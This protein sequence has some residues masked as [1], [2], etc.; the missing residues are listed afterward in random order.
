MDRIINIGQRDF[1]QFITENHFY[2]DKTKFIKEWWEQRDVVTLIIRPEKFGK[3]LNISMLETFF[4]IEYADRGELFEGLSIWKEEKYR[5]LQGTYPVIS[6]SFADVKGAD[7][8]ETKKSLNQVLENLYN[9]NRFLLD[10]KLLDKNEKIYFQ[11]VTSDM[12]GL[13]A[14]WAIYKMSDFLF[15]YYGKHVIVLV[16]E[17]DAPMREAYVNGYWKEMAGLIRSMFNTSFK[18]NP[19]LEQAVMT[20]MTTSSEELI[21][22]DL[23]MEIIT[24]TSKKYTDSFGF[25]EEEVFDA[26]NEFGMSDRQADVKRWY[27]GFVFGN[28]D[29]LYNPWSVMNYLDKKELCIYWTDTHSYSLTGNVTQR[30]SRNVKASFE[31]L[32]SGEHLTVSIDETIAYDRL[33]VDENAIWSFLLASGYVK[34][35]RYEAITDAY[36]GWKKEY[37]LELTNFEVKALFREMIQQWFYSARPEYQG[38]IKALLQNDVKAMNVYM[39]KV[40]MRTFSYFDTGKKPSKKE[41]ERF[42]HGFILGLIVELQERYVLTSNR[43]SGFG[44]YD[45]MLEPRNQSDDAIILECK[46]FQPRKE[47]ELT[48]TVE[49]ALKQ[50]EEK[51][52]ET[53]LIAK[54]IAK[55]RIRKY[56]FAFRGNEVLIGQA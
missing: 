16:D 23:N 30:G 42:Y 46:V 36:G 49:A 35:D 14:V 41:P 2:I 37:T 56:G 48:E 32:L 54:G 17:Y 24:T 27:G 9:K 55:E 28:R 5:N 47:K 26:L 7:Y 3:T 25:T 4:S 20:G 34:L 52:Y 8:A 53:I 12:D 13:T 39:N 44:R 33:D 6:L 43:E 21:L 11:S 50:I 51:D 18:T 10:G 19:Y 40:A 1:G 15:R 45:V 22:S 29:D 38:F 31:R